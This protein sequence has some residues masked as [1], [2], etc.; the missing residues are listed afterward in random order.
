MYKIRSFRYNKNEF[1]I[2]PVFYTWMVKKY[3]I[4][5]FSDILYH[6]QNVMTVL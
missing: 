6:F 5:T 4:S 3:D 1:I 2:I